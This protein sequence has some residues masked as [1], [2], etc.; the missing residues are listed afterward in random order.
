MDTAA[1]WF[2]V[3]PHSADQSRSASLPPASVPP[4]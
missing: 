4:G 2:D 3:L 1:K